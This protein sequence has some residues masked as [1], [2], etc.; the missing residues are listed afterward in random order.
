MEND[1]LICPICNRQFV[2]SRANKY[3]YFCSQDYN[4]CPLYFCI[5]NTISKNGTLFSQNNILI[6]N[7]TLEEAL[8]IYKTLKSFI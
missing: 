3:A 6:E 4:I 2:Q 1:K 5:T 8:K 7:Q